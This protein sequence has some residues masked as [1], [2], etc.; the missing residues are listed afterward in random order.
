MK[1]L[2]KLVILLLGLILFI[3][4]CAAEP[5]PV[6]DTVQ[7][8][9]EIAETETELTET[10]EYIKIS[11]EEAK[12]MIDNQEVIIVD[13]RTEAEFAEGHIEGALLIPETEIA[14][15][16]A[17]LLPDKEATILIYCRSGRRSEIASR[18]LLDLGYTEVYD[19][20]GIIDWPYAIIVE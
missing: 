13:V 12:L 9:Q 10:A 15:V 20:G 8:N 3:S 4:S 2:L 17:E 11:A 7:E 19:F 5:V 16:A 1:R 6:A 14:A 18:I